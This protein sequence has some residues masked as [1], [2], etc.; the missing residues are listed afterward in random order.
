MKKNTRSAVALLMF[1]G[2]YSG[3]NCAHGGGGHG[4]YGGHGGGGY[5]GHGGYGG[6]YRGHSSFGFSFGVPY[7]SY[8]YY[9]YPYYAPP[10]ITVPSAPPVYIQ[11]APPVIQQTPPGYWYYCTNPQGYYP[12]IKQCLNSW[13]QV[14][15]IP[16][17]PR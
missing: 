12:Y 7:Y 2:L 10:V 13:Q 9:S 8:P 4:G 17:S 1:C 14:E 5:Y 11:Q 15:P 3:I 6:G 16:P